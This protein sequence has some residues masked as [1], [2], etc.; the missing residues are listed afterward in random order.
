MFYC[1][2]LWCIYYFINCFYLNYIF[3]SLFSCRSS[4]RSLPTT[5]RGGVAW[6][7]KPHLLESHKAYTKHI[8]PF[9]KKAERNGRLK[10]KKHHNSA[11]L[12]FCMDAT[13]TECVKST[14]LPFEMPFLMWWVAQRRGIQRILVFY[15]LCRLGSWE[16]LTSGAFFSCNIYKTNKW[17]LF[18]PIQHL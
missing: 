13:S 5:H 4:D 16:A 2:F 11:E 10:S 12:S 14:Q 17:P 7:L 15:Q 9:K 1:I 18:M 8:P 3:S 6:H